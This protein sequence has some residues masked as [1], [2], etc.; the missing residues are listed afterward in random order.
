MNPTLSYAPLFQFKLSPDIRWRKI[1]DVIETM[2]ID[3]YTFVKI[4]PETLS[5]LAAVAFKEINHKFRASHLQSWS[6]I[7]SDPEASENDRFVALELLKNANIS[8]SGVLPSCQDTG[9][10]IVTG[11]RGERIITGGCDE[12]A[13]TAGIAAAYRTGNL[14]YSQIAPLSML[15]ERN[16][17]TNLPAQI[18]LMY[19]GDNSEYTFLFIAKGGGSA[20]KT[21][22]FPKTKAL[23]SNEESLI[24]FVKEEIVKLGTSACPPYHLSLVIG[25]LSAEMTL[26][27]VKMASCKFYDELATTGDELGRAFR[28]VLWERKILN[29]SRKVGIGAQFG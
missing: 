13:L 8:I 27:T 18:D 2:N 5:N 3:G 9:T 10:A 19:G 20:N 23:I 15:V 7:L 4:A 14:R 29:L 6:D 16:T 12:A 17:K 25:G 21:A 26:K 22:L 24:N 28:D 1:S 11:Y